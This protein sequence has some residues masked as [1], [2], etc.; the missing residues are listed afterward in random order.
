MMPC[1]VY[2]IDLLHKY[3]SQL[4]MLHITYVIQQFMHMCIL[5]RYIVQCSMMVIVVAGQVPVVLYD[6]V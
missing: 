2:S 6:V 4:V 1:A 5:C 3:V